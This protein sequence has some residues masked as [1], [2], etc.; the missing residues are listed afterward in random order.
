MPV[1]SNHQADTPSST[2]FLYEKPVDI[3]LREPLKAGDQKALVVELPEPPNGDSTDRAFFYRLSNG[4]VVGYFNRCTHVTVP[5]NFDDDRFLDSA[6][7]IMCR[8]H[9]ARYELE[10][11]RV[12]LGPAMGNLTRVLF[13]ERPG[14]LRVLGW[15]RVR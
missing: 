5:L 14:V 6:G 1:T 12:C 9:G 15:E 4:E 8:L 2:R 11:G 7:F 10:T 13:E 3:V